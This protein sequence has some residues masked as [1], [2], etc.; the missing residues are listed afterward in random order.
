MNANIASHL[1]NTARLEPDRTAVR[2][3]ATG[4]TLTYG[5]LAERS[6]RIAAG[7]LEQGLQVGDR[8]ALLLRN[9]PEYIEV[10]F[11]VATAGL[12]IVPFNTRLATKDFAH[13]LADAGC[14]A[15]I[16]EPHFLAALKDVGPELPL[17]VDISNSGGHLGLDDLLGHE[18]IDVAFREDSDVCS[19]MYTS[20]TTGTPKAVMLSHRAWTS[21]SET[22]EAILSF[23]PG[24]SVLHPAPLTHGAGFLMLPTIRHAGVN[25]TTPNFD[26]AVTAELMASGQVQGMFLVP[27]MVRMILDEMAETWRPADGFAWIF[28]A[29]SPIEVQT[30]REASRRF[31]SRLV[32][33]FAQMEAPMFLTYLGQDEHRAALNDDTSDLAR[34][35]GYVIPGREVLIV[36][37]K[38]DPVRAG[39]VGEVVARAPQMMLGY[40][41]REEATRETIRDGWLHTGDLGY[42]DA[43]GKLFVV[44]RVKDMIVTG[45]S[46]VFAREVEDVLA[47]APGVADV[48]IIGLPHRIWG[49]EVTAVVVAAPGSSLSEGELRD[50]CRER[51]AGYKIP[52]RVIDVDALPRNAYGKVLKRQLRDALADNGTEPA[53]SAAGS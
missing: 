43:D 30:L 8:V 44:D 32:Q 31:D 51:L 42:F 53:P 40:W 2:D 17:L 50:Y 34:S 26:P 36:D 38:G 29:G 39:T 18:P 4:A 10:F 46:N 21:V 19:L 20:G 47:H 24:M 33:S 16:T 52:K 11:G 45:G 15:L 28:Y 41:N 22:S 48:A 12:V 9:S 13:M 35:A 6:A 27:S 49:E 7:L 23:T 37:D 14:S 5:E 3:H 1:A 25:V